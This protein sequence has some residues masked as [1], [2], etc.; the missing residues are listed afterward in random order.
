MK[1]SVRIRKA[2]PG[3]TP[4]Y[5]NKTAKFL[6]K[7]QMGMQVDSPSMDPQRLNKVYENV[8][9]SLKQSTPP[10]V[11][12]NE[13]VTE[14]ALDQDT[15]LSI[16]R[17][18]L[19][20]LSQEGYFDESELEGESTSQSEEET[21]EEDTSA[22]EEQ[23]ASDDAEQ[24]QLAESSEGYYD[25]EEALN[26]DTSHLEDEQYEQQE[27]FRYG[28]YWQ[29]GGESEEVY[30]ESEY[31]DEENYS[32]E[33]DT[34]E[35]VVDQYNYPGQSTMEKPFSIEDLMAITPGMQ[36]QEAFPDISAYLGDYQPVADSYQPENYLPQAQYGTIIKAAK[37]AADALKVDP[38]ILRQP[39]TNLST[40]RKY[41]PISTLTGEAVTKLPLIGSKLAP[42]LATTFTQ[43]R[44]ELFKVMQGQSPKTGIFSQTGSYAGGADGSLSADRLLLYQ[45]DVFNI[46]DQIE[47][48]GRSAFQFMD[49]DPVAK[50]DGLISGLYPLDSKIVSGVDDNGFKFF[51]LNKTFTPGEKLPFGT[52]PSKAKEVTFKNRFYY[53][54]D[55]AGQVQVFDSLGNPLSQ[56]AQ[57][58]FEVAR[59]FGTTV[60]RTL[61][62]PILRNSNTP[63]PSFRTGY[64]GGRLT[65]TMGEKPMTFADMGVRGKIGRGLETF[66]FTGLNLPFRTGADAIQKVDYPVFGYTNKALG[67]N[68]IDPATEGSY[69]KDIANAMNYKYRVGRNTLLG[70]GALGALGYTGYNAYNKC[71]CEDPLAPNYQMKDKYDNCPCGTD[72]GS[73]RTLDPTANP[74]TE[75]VDPRSLTMPDSMQFLIQKGIYP[76]AEN[77]YRYQ[78]SNVVNPN[79][80]NSIPADDFAYGGALPRAQKGRIIKGVAKTMKTLKAQ[81]TPKGV[82]IPK[83]MSDIPI[84]KYNVKGMDAR[85]AFEDDL[86][87]DQDF[88]DFQNNDQF[89]QY[90]PGFQTNQQRLD[91]EPL[92]DFFKYVTGYS[93]P[94]EIKQFLNTPGITKYNKFGVPF[95]T[96]DF[97][98]MQT[99]FEDPF[100]LLDDGFNI[101]PYQKGGISKNQF[102][103]KF[104]SMYQEGG[105]KDP[106][107][108]S[109]GKGK[110]FD[111]L[112]NDVE[113]RKDIFKS[114]L[115]NNSNV[116][117]T[118]E[119]YKN[120]Q[121]NPQILSMLMQ[122][123]QK[124]NLAE[125]D[126]MQTAQYGGVKEDSIPNWY[127]GYQSMMTPAQ[128]KKLYKQ[129]RRMI[130]KGVDIS[131]ANIASNFFDRGTTLPPYGH[132]MTYPQYDDMMNR[133]TMPMMID[134][135]TFG[136]R[137]TSIPSQL[138]AEDAVN[139]N[140]Q[141]GTQF[142]PELSPDFID[143]PLTP[144]LKGQDFLQFYEDYPTQLQQKD[145]FPFVDYP[146][147][148]E[149]GGFVDTDAEEPLYKFIYG[150]DEPEYY[151]QYGL[152]EA[153]YGA[154]VSGIYDYIDGLQKNAKNNDPDPNPKENE[155]KKDD[156]DIIECG[157]GTVWSKTY[158]SCIP[159]SKVTYNQRQ[160]R[161]SPGFF[162]T[163]LPWNAPFGYAGSWT[164]QM[165]LPYYLGSKD[166]YKGQLTGAP[167]ARYVTKKGILGRPKKWIDIYNTGSGSGSIN[168]IELEKLMEQNRRGSNRNM[169]KNQFNNPSEDR[170]SGRDQLESDLKKRMGYSDEEWESTSEK[171]K[172]REIRAER[173]NQGKG[174]RYKTNE[175]YENL[176]DSALGN[177]AKFYGNIGKKVKN[178][179][180]RK[181]YG[182]AGGWD[183]F[184]LGSGLSTGVGQNMSAFAPYSQQQQFENSLFGTKGPSAAPKPQQNPL[185]NVNFGTGSYAETA[186]TGHTLGAQGQEIIPQ[187]EPEAP[188]NEYVGVENKR[189]DMQNVDP[190]AGVNVTNA[191]IRGGLGVLSRMQ[192]A[193]RERNFL[194]DTVDP[195][196]LYASAN[197]TDRGD[198]QDFG[199]KS[200][201]LRYDQEGQDRSS[202][203][204]YG[205]YANAAYGGYMQEGG[206]YEEPYFEEDEEVY[207]T[208]DELEQFLQAGGQVEYL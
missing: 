38:P 159:R 118:E 12:Y 47:N 28:G 104:T 189:K 36:G 177:T 7:A 50:N 131:K 45:D 48:G 98:M 9:I 34:R 179:L 3:E 197:E 112:T 37:A 75:Q 120:A 199:S 185:A 81:P 6:Q 74:F 17:A 113:A 117:L 128:Y 194:L 121:S 26:N 170:V 67:P 203:A 35:N 201:M 206:F 195:M 56:G 91:S 108:P 176:K 83:N 25:D 21:Q 88:I 105:E 164:K 90:S 68:V 130:P 115:K 119:I 44:D 82:T 15:S 97:K 62:D 10:D 42:K 181:D 18:A 19:G 106:K 16:L 163:M 40:L 43:N 168:P 153:Q 202:R 147:V 1:K 89:L 39:F 200:G 124:E 208:P 80:E 54:T 96:R 65:E 95:A 77:Y 151:E 182:G 139:K 57:T 93:D 78:D 84:P 23:Q 146:A 169:N 109:L 66:G 161:R 188:E 85:K 198:W 158:Q 61:T 204:T 4:G 59:P 143:S 29:D 73:R 111:T 5:Y 137:G 190:E 175:A 114:K 166:P 165:S 2:L 49:I 58:K 86:R 8:Y 187:K 31:Q 205:N 193:G 152:P 162:N 52:L 41:I 127:R 142:L 167:V 133:M 100:N 20:Q 149:H 178:F 33:S 157:P 107:D 145:F 173:Y 180:T 27:A 13:L 51:E 192:N 24:Q 150:G 103:K 156:Q 196:N 125:N 172:R 72:V 184:A 140:N 63:F 102:I 79:M 144:E 92:R 64:E 126:N 132:V 94:L 207:M 138:Q 110:R 122:D 70:L 69:A 101:P 11:V 174:L 116:A 191:A 53:K 60:S 123:G 71:Q 136:F 155:D 171:D 154:D 76:S 30:D 186:N 55:E 129:L 46:I 141:K 160:V 87:L 183:P 134:P 135:N 99:P 148:A 14:Y 32:D 22:Q